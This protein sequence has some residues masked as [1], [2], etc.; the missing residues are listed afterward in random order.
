[1]PICL[2]Y[3]KLTST[4]CER[5]TTIGSYESLNEAKDACSSNLACTG[6]SDD[7]CYGFIWNLCSEALRDDSGSCAWKKTGCSLNSH[8]PKG[9][10]CHKGYCRGAE[11]CSAR[12]SGEGKAYWSG[13]IIKEYTDASE[14]NHKYANTNCK[15][16][17]LCQH[18]DGCEFWDFETKDIYVINKQPKGTCRLRS[19]EGKGPEKKGDK[20]QI[21]RFGKKFCI[22]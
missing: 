18:T 21:F 10:L 11:P 6:I 17:K 5:S 14:H 1:M 12:G 22:C 16:Q 13:T 7:G 2:G 19:N 9:K 3:K 20:S 4:S 8:C 15:C